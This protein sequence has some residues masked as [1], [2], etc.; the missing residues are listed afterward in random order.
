M[1]ERLGTAENQR[2][3]RDMQLKNSD[4]S[5]WKSEAYKGSLKVNVAPFPSLLFSTQILPPCAS[6]MLLEMNSPRPVPV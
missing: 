5:K 1:T 6:I 4:E 2:G 3:F